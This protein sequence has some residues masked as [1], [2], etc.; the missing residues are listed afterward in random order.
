MASERDYD[1]PEKSRRTGAS[2]VARKFRGRRRERKRI[3]GHAVGVR[4]LFPLAGKDGGTTDGG[5]PR[6]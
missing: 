1:A 4:S 6:W 5:A 2:R 3:D